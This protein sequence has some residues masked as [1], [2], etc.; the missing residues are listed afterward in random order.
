MLLHFDINIKINQ[1]YF[2]YLSNK[3]QKYFMV[4]IMSKDRFIL[5]SSEVRTDL[6]D[7][8]VKVKEPVSTLNVS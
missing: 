8:T 4:E 5:T 6:Q 3:H 1:S 2:L 7:E